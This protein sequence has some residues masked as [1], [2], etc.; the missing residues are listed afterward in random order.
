M[1]LIGL[2]ASMPW[3]L[4]DGLSI[5]LV[6]KERAGMATGIFN[7]TRV[8]GEGIALAIVTAV[9]AALLQS[10]LTTSLPKAEGASTTRL[11][12]VAERIATGNLEQ[13]AKLLP[14]VDRP[15]LAQSYAEAFQVLTYILIAI[16]LISAVIVFGFLGRSAGEDA[17]AAP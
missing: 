14:G 15:F 4:M 2:G 5:S 6:P 9:L 8:A 13:A 7:I 3:G 11:M 12:N 10:S 1:L 17:R 16:T